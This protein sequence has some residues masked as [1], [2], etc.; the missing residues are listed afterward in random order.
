MAN[1]QNGYLCSKYGSVFIYVYQLTWLLYYVLYIAC[2][3][4]CEA[5]YEVNPNCSK[6]NLT[7]IC[8]AEIPCQNNGICIL[9]SQP[10]N[11]TCNCT[12]TGYVGTNCTGMSAVFQLYI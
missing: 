10:D 5:G 12:N 3:L 4:L 8:E 7:N 9:G 6:C 11:Y 1:E 2:S